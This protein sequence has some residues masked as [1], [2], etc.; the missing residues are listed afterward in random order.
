MLI[1]TRPFAF[2][3]A[4]LRPSASVWLACGSRAFSVRSVKD[5]PRSEQQLTEDEKQMM[6]QALEEEQREAMEV[7]W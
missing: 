1:S 5:E 7:C 4:F 3:L 6:Q 2:G